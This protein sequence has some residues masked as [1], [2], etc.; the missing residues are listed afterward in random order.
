MGEGNAGSLYKEVLGLKCVCCIGFYCDG[1]CSYRN[2]MIN[3]S[4]LIDTFT[5]QR[6]IETSDSMGG[7]VTTW[8]SHFEFK[9]RLSGL[10]INESMS[11]DRQAVYGTHKIYSEIYDEITP[12]WR[13]K[14]GDRIFEIIGINKPSNF[15]RGF[16]EMTVKEIT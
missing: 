3:R 10:S 11:A 13:I 9:G 8:A 5:A 15:Q 12:Q 14:L 6:P 2:Y 4:L 16:L 1:R 7:Y